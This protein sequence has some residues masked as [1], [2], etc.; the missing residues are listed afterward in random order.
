[1]QPIFTT[2]S[3]KPIFL[4][5]G[6]DERVD[7][8]VEKNL[9]HVHRVELPELRYHWQRRSSDSKDA[10]LDQLSWLARNVASQ[11]NHCHVDEYNFIIFAAR[12]HGYKALVT[13]HAFYLL[14]HDMPKHLELWMMKV[15]RHGRR[16]G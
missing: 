1:M 5:T 12:Y 15:T 16:V 13:V 9:R 7:R 4:T 2:Q 11:V 14:P 6:G 3:T 10:I 8:R